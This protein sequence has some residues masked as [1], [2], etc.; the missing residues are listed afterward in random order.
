[1]SAAAIDNAV[2]ARLAGDAV[3][4]AL[5]P[6]GVWFGAAP[7]GLTAFALV[8]PVSSSEEAVFGPP[9]ARRAW[10]ETVYAI[11]AVQQGS[12]LAPAQDAAGRIDTLL[13]D[14]DLTVAGYACLIVDRPARI[15]LTIVDAVDARLQ[16]HQQGGQYR[17]RMTPV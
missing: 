5:V 4:T 2:V 13:V 9:G 17:V 12:A 16:W 8:V 14:H 15:A 7:S 6:D 10:E 3:L 11:A 1:M